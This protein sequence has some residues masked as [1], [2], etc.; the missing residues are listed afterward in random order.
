MRRGGSWEVLRS[1]VGVQ[2]I[3]RNGRLPRIQVFGGQECTEM[4]GSE[5]GIVNDGKLMPTYEE[6][7][8]A[9]KT[10]IL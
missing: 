8:E 4:Q 9:K 5:K 2:P 3:V 7:L 1:G 6:C 10:P